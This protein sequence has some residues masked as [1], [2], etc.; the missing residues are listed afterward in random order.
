MFEPCKH[1]MCFHQVAC[2]HSLLSVGVL[3]PTA[4]WQ[5][6]GCVAQ[7]RQWVKSMRRAMKE[8]THLHLIVRL[9]LHDEGFPFRKLDSTVT[10]GEG[11][12][13]Y[14]AGI[15][16]MH[17][18]GRLKPDDSLQLL[19][20]PALVNISRSVFE[21]LAKE[22]PILQHLSLLGLCK[23]GALHTFGVNCPELH[24]LQVEASSVS[25]EALY[26]LG[27]HLP[28]LSHFK[29]MK[30]GAWGNNLQAFATDALEELGPCA[31]LKSLVVDFGRKVQIE[32]ERKVW[33]SLPQSLVT[34]RCTCL[35]L[36]LRGATHM[37]QT[38]Q[39]L[40]VV[41]PPYEDLFE[42]A[43][44][45]PCLNVLKV[46]GNT[47]LVLTSQLLDA[48]EDTSLSDGDE[49]PDP[50]A[51]NIDISCLNL[52]VKATNADACRIFSRLRQFSAC[53]KVTLHVSE[54]TELNQLWL[55]HWVPKLFPRIVTLEIM[56]HGAVFGAPF[57]APGWA[58][59]CLGLLNPCTFLKELFL[60]LPMHLTSARMLELCLNITS[61]Q[62]VRFVPCPGVDRKELLKHL[63]LQKPS[64]TITSYGPDTA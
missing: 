40:D 11:H 21:I 15:C 47:P 56:D 46:S 63:R 59:T 30:R 25:P 55:M 3:F 14:K 4:D 54:P 5:Q 44:F 64:C 43:M 12:L 33:Q 45:L 10:D 16:N 60:H 2:N 27:T 24:S 28:S 39:H 53:N 57:P 29:L 8:V 17:L 42:L 52:L 50:S 23:D 32:C 6:G 38:L 41:C 51:I 49:L 9:V 26:D 20:S 22:V 34:L 18:E 19:H 1:N 61:L 36:S 31:N 48:A 13:S 7:A 37:F 35:I 62:T 58:G